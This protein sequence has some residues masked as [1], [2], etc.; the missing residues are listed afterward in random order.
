MATTNTTTLV[1]LQATDMSEKLQSHRISLPLLRQTILSYQANLQR[2]TANT[3]TRGEVRGGGKK[4][5]RQKGTGR[6]RVGSS[7]NPIWRT[8]GIVFGPTTEKNFSQKITKTAKLRT[9]ADAIKLKVKA[10]NAH[11]LNISE[12]IAKTKQAAVALG[13]IATGYKLLVVVPEMSWAKGF[14]NLP[15]TTAFTVEQLTAAN[16]SRVKNIVF[17]GNTWETTL[18]KFE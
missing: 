14:I 13:E 4:P 16:V 2:P 9:L 15:N 1:A 18:T 8:G 7:R 17:L 10:G 3:K 5:W 6:A 11:T 12:P